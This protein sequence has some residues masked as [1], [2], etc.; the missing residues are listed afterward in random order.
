MSRFH[1]S[2]RILHTQA[3]CTSTRED[4][5]RSERM[6]LRLFGKFHGFG[7]ARLKCIRTSF[8]SG[9]R[10]L[11]DRLSFAPR[12]RGS[13]CETVPVVKVLRPKRRPQV[14]VEDKVMVED[15]TRR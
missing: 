5:K 4:I 15:V 12:S 7:E 13:P 2:R 3:H 6:F 10:I 8:A 14:H 1:A 9:S 11:L